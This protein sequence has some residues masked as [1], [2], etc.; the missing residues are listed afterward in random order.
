MSVSQTPPIKS[1]PSPVMSHGKN[2][3]QLK[4]VTK[5]FPSDPGFTNPPSN[6]TVIAN[7]NTN[8]SRKGKF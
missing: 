3:S 2:T 1:T 8:N 4:E 5:R 7:S 6:K